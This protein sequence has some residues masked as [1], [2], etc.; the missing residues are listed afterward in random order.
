[1]TFSDGTLLKIGQT[2]IALSGSPDSVVKTILSGKNEVPAMDATD[3]AKAKP[4]EETLLLN[5]DLSKDYSGMPI[6]DIDG[7][8]V[9]VAVVRE[10]GMT[11]YPVNA[12]Q[13]AIAALSKTLPTA[14]TSN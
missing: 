14:S 5:N 4:A 11:V 12:V 1:V 10:S 9:G 6:V 13:A 8:V 7:G 3:T 2:V